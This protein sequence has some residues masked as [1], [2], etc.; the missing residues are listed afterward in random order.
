MLQLGALST[1]TLKHSPPKKSVSI[2]RHSFSQIISSHFLHESWS[3]ATTERWIVLLFCIAAVFFMLFV[4]FV[5]APQHMSFV[6]WPDF[7][8]Y[9][10]VLFLLDIMRGIRGCLPSWD[11]RMRLLILWSLF[12]LALCINLLYLE[13]H[14]YYQ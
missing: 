4:V 6:L 2:G 14:Y 1:K 10:W 7:N 3:A 8:L 12:Y 5:S 13:L 9:L 11:V